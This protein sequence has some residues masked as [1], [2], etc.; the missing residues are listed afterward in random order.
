MTPNDVSPAK[1][2]ARKAARAH[3]DALAPHER[4]I[5]SSVI[6]ERV[7]ELLGDAR[8]V[9]LYAPTGSEVE[10]WLIDE[11]VRAIG[12]R[13]VYPRVVDHARELEF[14]YTVPEQLV[15]W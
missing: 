6:A 4:E 11:H 13:V 9:A 8:T 15:A 10:T 12:G 14:H 5:A 7:N 3:R 2:S 1:P